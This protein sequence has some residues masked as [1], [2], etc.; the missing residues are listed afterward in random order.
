MP[1]INK[2]YLGF[3]E[4]KELLGVITLGYG[5]QPLQTIKKIFYKHNVLSKDYLEIGKMCFIPR[6]NDTKSFGSQVISM[7]VKWLKI[8]L[9]EVS[10]LY[11]LADGIM[12]KVGYVYQASN[13]Y[14]IGQFSKC[15]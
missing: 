14:Y 4:K 11:T 8:N 10:F 7:L 9:P 6:M 1:R 13:F 15:L 3:Y 5:T 2:Y 12:G